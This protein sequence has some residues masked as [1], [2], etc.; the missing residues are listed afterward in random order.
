MR[1]S[2]FRTQRSLTPIFAPPAAASRHRPAHASATPAN[3]VPPGSLRFVPSFQSSAVKRNFLL[4]PIRNFSLCRD[5][6]MPPAAVQHRWVLSCRKPA[7]DGGR[8]YTA[9]K[10]RIWAVPA[11]LFLFFGPMAGPPAS[12]QEPKRI[13]ILCDAFGPSAG[14]LEMDWGFSALVEYEGKRILFDT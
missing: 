8:M 10:G 1:L 2:S 6:G 5:S 12:A 3:L 4:C 9:H 13:T 7:A 14:A 11:I